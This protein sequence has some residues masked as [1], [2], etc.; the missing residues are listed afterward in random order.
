MYNF[1]KVYDS[2]SH[3]L[4][5]ITV[6]RKIEYR[7]LSPSPEFLV[8]RWAEDPAFQM[9][10]LVMVMLLRPHFEKHFSSERF[11]GLCIKLSASQV[12]LW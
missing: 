8:Q 9:S 11:N 10:F 6:T 5:C 4:A 2:D 1:L 12:A 7:L 3:I